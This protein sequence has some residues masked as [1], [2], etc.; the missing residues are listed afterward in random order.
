MN[1]VT[2]IAVRVEE[3]A[4][5]LSMHVNAIRKAIYG[6]ELPVFQHAPNKPYY[7][8]VSDLVDWFNRK[9]RVR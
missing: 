4:A 1:N 2:K 6:R 5:L 9:K 3:A 8:L 7:I